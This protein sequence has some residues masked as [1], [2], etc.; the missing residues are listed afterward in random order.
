MAENAQQSIYAC[1]IFIDC[2]SRLDTPNVSLFLSH[3]SFPF[4]CNIVQYGL[5]T[6]QVASTHGVKV[7]SLNHLQ[8][9]DIRIGFAWYDCQFRGSGPV[10]NKAHCQ[11]YVMWQ[12][13][14]AGPSGVVCSSLFAGDTPLV[15]TTPANAILVVGPCLWVLLTGCAYENR[16]RCTQSPF[17]VV[18]H[19]TISFKTSFSRFVTAL[20]EVGGVS[21]YTCVQV[22]M[23]LCVCVC[24]CVCVYQ[25]STHAQ[26]T[27]HM[28]W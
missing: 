4:V 11:T 6:T 28:Q 26:G 14:T 1:H 8:E 22:H 25:F 24:V 10:P 9:L 5:C 13:S 12:S 18:M 21:L 15:Y 3:P 20:F 19:T 7:M 16:P 2:T 23:C 17:Q 27:L